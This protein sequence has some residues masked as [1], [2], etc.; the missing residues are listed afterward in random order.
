M[1]FSL[2]VLNGKLEVEV[3]GVVGAGVRDAG[4]GT[5]RG[6]LRPAGHAA[7][8]QDR[9][10]SHLVGG[11]PETVRD[12]A[13]IPL[14]ET[15]ADELMALTMVHDLDARVES[16]RILADVLLSGAEG[17][18]EGVIGSAARR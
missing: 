3:G 12:K 16:Y 1:G 7:C 8:V 15:G 5:R 17:S 6:A 9:L 4:A 18:A 10:A 11:G 2:G 13:R 14:A